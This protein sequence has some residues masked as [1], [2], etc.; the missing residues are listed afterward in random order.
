MRANPDRRFDLR[1][2]KAI[3]RAISTYE[4]LNILIEHFVEGI[5]RAFKVKGAGI[6]LYDE[7]DGQLFHV[8]SYGI[9]ENYLNKGPVFLNHQDDALAKGEPVFVQDIRN[10]VRIQYPEAAAAEKIHSM[11]SFPIKCRDAT[12]GMLRIYHSES[13]DLHADDIDSISTLALHLGLVIQENG[14]RN[15]AQMIG[16]TISSLPPRLRRGV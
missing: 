9:S 16:G 5:T 11:L 8:S 1:A 3:S 14:L 10:D 6:L 15:F 4:D 12:L 7:A 13:I 2:F